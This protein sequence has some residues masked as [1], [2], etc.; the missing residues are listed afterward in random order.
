MARSM[1][2]TEAKI[3]RVLKAIV[4]NGINVDKIDI[5]ADRVV[6]MTNCDESGADP[7]SSKKIKNWTSS[8]FDNKVPG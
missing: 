3:D 4:N 5:L 8:P 6:V 7:K 2:I 1:T